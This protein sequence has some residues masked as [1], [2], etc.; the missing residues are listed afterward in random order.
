[1]QGKFSW[2]IV[3]R[4]NGA[5]FSLARIGMAWVLVLCTARKNTWKME[6]PM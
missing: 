3:D 4:M 6:H 2:K 1:M 5:R